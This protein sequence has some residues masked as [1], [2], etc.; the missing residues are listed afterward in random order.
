METS[1]GCKF[2]TNFSGENPSICSFELN[3]NGFYVGITI[4]NQK[5]S[6][7][8]P[9]PSFYVEEEKNSITL[10]PLSLFEKVGGLNG[11]D[12]KSDLIVCLK[13]YFKDKDIT[14]YFFQAFIPTSTRGLG[15]TVNLGFQ[16]Y[17]TFFIKDKNNALTVYDT[18]TW[19]CNKATNQIQENN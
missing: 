17:I 13:R 19:T 1:L 18:G 15:E 16:E 11:E 14:G 3:E 7:T 10:Y 4:L 6:I 8:P 2:E 5:Y 12:P 9:T